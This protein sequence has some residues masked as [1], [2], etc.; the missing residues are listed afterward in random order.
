MLLAQAKRGRVAAWQRG[1]GFNGVNLKEREKK[2]LRREG[3]AREQPVLGVLISYSH[4]QCCQS[5]VAG[6]TPSRVVVH[7]CMSIICPLLMSTLAYAAGILTFYLSNGG[8]SR[9][10]YSLRI[11][12]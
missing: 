3:K 5:G 11:T 8:T 1:M 12:R 7:G 4:S 10:V 9:Q 6:V 2:R